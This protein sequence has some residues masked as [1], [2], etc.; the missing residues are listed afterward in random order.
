M[1]YILIFVIGS[2]IGSFL[3]VCIYRLPRNKSIIFPS[4]YCPSCNTKIKW[5]DNIPIISFIL[6][7]GKC[8]SCKGKI[9]LRYPLVEILT[10][11]LLIL[12]YSR[13]SLSLSF[14]A[15]SLLTF[16]LIIVTFIDFE[17]QII[18]DEITY[19]LIVIGL[20]LSFFS[21]RIGIIDSILGILICGGLLYLI[22]IVSRGGMGGGDVKLAAA[23]GSFLGFKAGLASLVFAF[24]SGGLVGAILLLTG[25]KGRKDPIPFGPFIVFGA[26]II[27]LFSELIPRVFLFFGINIA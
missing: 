17:Q 18:P 23:I 20:I 21:P 9:S 27:V 6:L 1:I 16:S 10:S 2:I 25:I 19:P 15:Y 24:I 14:F 4:S 3:N 8:R 26:L 11:V 13:Y 7:Q 22:V 12:L 5:F